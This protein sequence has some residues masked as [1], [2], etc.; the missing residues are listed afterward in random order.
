MEILGYII[1]FAS[2]L[3]SFTASF[4]HYMHMFQLNSYSPFEQGQWM[5]KNIGTI[6]LRHI[7]A[8]AAIV[9]LLVFCFGS[10]SYQP[11]QHILAGAAEQIIYG[12]TVSHFG[13]T[14]STAD[15]LIC[16]AILA[17][18]L[19]FCRHK[20]AKKKLKFTP[21]VIRMCVTSTIVYGAV[22]ALS[23]IFLYESGLFLPVLCL[24]QIFSLVMP[25]IANFIN[26]PIEKAVNNHYIHDAKRIINELPNTTVIGITGSYGKTS[27]KFYLNKLLSAK[28]NVLMTPESYNTT[29]GVVITIRKRLNASHEIFICEM[30]AKGVGE[31]KE[32]C[33]IVHPKHSMITSIG[34][35]HLETFKSVD[36]IIKTKFEIADC[37]T[38]GTVVL[39]F[40]NEHIRN[41]GTDK[42]KITYG[43]G[44]G[45]Y[46]YKAENI[47]VSPKGTSF[48]VVH[49][50]ERYDFSTKL[51]GSH[52]VQNIVG[53]IAVANFMGVPFKDLVFP[54]K[55]LECV[56][57]R[58]EILDKGNGVT[59]ID[60]AFNS[61]P[62]G[63]RA[64]LGT[65][66][67][68][69]DCERILVTPGM[70]ELGEREY[71]LNREL[72]EF[73]ADCCDAAILVGER[74]A[75]P[76]KEGLLKKGYPEDK[77]YVVKD[78]NEGVKIAY[79]LNA[80]RKRVILL[81]NDLPDNY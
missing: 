72:G 61:N 18:S 51:L 39:N 41:H 68:M 54:V 13:F 6:I 50:G 71:E 77:I 10:Y 32:I 37:I 57:H 79:G 42:N 8:V 31:I 19:I 1:F 46:D 33:D 34:E 78:L 44:D 3:I 2:L 21:R 69:E 28:Y 65:L 47:K 7:W 38:D 5:K 26:T 40:D 74:Q 63:A 45:D 64:A 81:E 56:P 53:A 27:T 75:P 80:G 16:A 9:Y 59:V 14:I 70:V 67:M 55:R 25:M 76:I 30:G 23:V 22:C 4:I 17:V 60:D 58:M 35:Q 73:A 11:H 24:W 12:D 48:T 43:I 66:S 62:A 36:N 29:M 20:P 15:L 49:K 52:N